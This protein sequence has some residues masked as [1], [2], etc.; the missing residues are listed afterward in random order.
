VLTLAACGSPDSEPEVTPDLDPS[1]T[2]PGTSAA[3]IAPAV[4]NIASTSADGATLAGLLTFT[5]TADGVRL[6]GTIRGL[7]PNSTHGFHLH[8]NGACGPGE[9][10]T[11]GG[12]AGG[13]WDPLN[14]NNHDGPEADFATRHAGDLGNLTTDRD[15]V[16]SL[17]MDLSNLT[18]S[19]ANAVLGRSVMVHAGIDDLETDPSGAAGG[20]IGCGVIVT[21]S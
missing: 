13:H 5:E 18:I 2:T 9:D 21:D 4:A 16:A 12:A 15:G 19:G 7:E 10:G 11:P 3:A 14:T 8:E 6:A 17:E 20:R 1:T